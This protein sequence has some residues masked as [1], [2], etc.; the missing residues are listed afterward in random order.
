MARKRVSLLRPQPMWDDLS[1]YGVPAWDRRRHLITFEAPCFVTAWY[2][3]EHLISYGGGRYGIPQNFWAVWALPDGRTVTLNIVVDH[4]G[5]T[6]RSVLVLPARGGPP[7]TTL[8]LRVPLSKLVRLCVARAG[9]TVTV[10]RGAKGSVRRLR[11]AVLSGDVEGF[12][13]AVHRPQ[14][15]KRLE[16]AFLEQVAQVYRDA[17][18]RGVPPTDEVAKVMRAARSTAGRYVVE[19]RRRKVLGPTTAGRAGELRPA[20]RPAKGDTGNGQHR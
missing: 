14:R 8:S 10:E 19:A 17:I 2:Q 4:S 20:K 3:N 5:P 18:T 9:G 7:L 1:A 11:P 13:Q 12:E 16:D 6:C 15:G